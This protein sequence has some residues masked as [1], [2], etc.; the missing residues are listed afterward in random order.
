MKAGLFIVVVFIVGVIIGLR[1]M[2]QYGDCGSGK[3]VF[4]GASFFEQYSKKHSSVDQ[5]TTQ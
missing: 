3:P 1:I 5:Q 4:R 2:H